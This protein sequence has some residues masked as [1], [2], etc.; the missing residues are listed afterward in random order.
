MLCLCPSQED[1]DGFATDIFAHMQADDPAT[2]GSI[3]IL[4]MLLSFRC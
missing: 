1:E 4:D 3:Q 2:I